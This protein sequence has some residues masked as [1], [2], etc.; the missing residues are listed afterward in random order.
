MDLKWNL[1]G[2][3]LATAS[4]DH[5]LKLFDIR[6]LREEMQV[7]RGHKKEAS[8]VSWHPCHEGLFASGGSDGALMFWHVGS[9]IIYENIF[10]PFWSLGYGHEDETFS[11]I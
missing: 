11:I 3:W 10:H 1:N 2:N 6:N 5:L 4:R 9:V 7:F 8:S